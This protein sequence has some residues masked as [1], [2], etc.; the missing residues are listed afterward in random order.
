M[1]Q[2]LTLRFALPDELWC[3]VW[4]HLP[5]EARVA[6]SHVSRRWRAAALASSRLWSRIDFNTSL[7]DRRRCYCMSSPSDVVPGRFTDAVYA[8]LEARLAAGLRFISLALHRARPLPISFD[9]HV[10]CR[11]AN[12]A[13]ALL[14]LCA[15][16][17]PHAARL[18]SL[19][20]TSNEV[21]AFKAFAKAVFRSYPS[22][23]FP[24]LHH[25]KLSCIFDAER[26][27]VHK[28]VHI[29]YLPKMTPA[30]ES[31]DLFHDYTWWNCDRD[32]NPSLRVNAYPLPGTVLPALK[33]LRYTFR[34][35]R[36]C[37]TVLAPCPNLSIAHLSLYHPRYGRN[38][39]S[40]EIAE[41]DV[42]RVC[43]LAE[44]IARI[45]VYYIKD[46]AMAQHVRRMFARSDREELYIHQFGAA[47]LASLFAIFSDI[48]TYAQLRVEICAESGG[49]FAVQVQDPDGA[50]SRCV[51][52]A[53]YYM[54]P[55]GKGCSAPG[56]RDYTL[57]RLWSS[58]SPTLVRRLALPLHTWYAMTPFVPS[59]PVLECL[60]LGFASPQDLKIA[61]TEP[62]APLD[63]TVAIMTLPELR[64]VVLYAKRNQNV[65]LAI[66]VLD[67]IVSSFSCDVDTVRL[68]NI[69]LKV[70][71]DIDV[72]D[73]M[74]AGRV[75]RFWSVRELESYEMFL[76]GDEDVPA[77]LFKSTRM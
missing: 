65:R 26:P 39:I 71:C 53:P 67:N 72:S 74:P 56:A 57:P 33:E 27:W 18:R 30:L 70:P 23:A 6:V 75:E 9:V 42:A 22:P 43:T 11:T 8:S 32:G 38:S 17:R 46:D 31:L 12:N 54:L 36:D 16:I 13:P 4:E 50:R 19:S 28:R 25:L 40:T 69:D 5:L 1:S 7:H 21:D 51:S 34:D 60:M 41:E 20:F 29:P 14:Q 77:A 55:N 3:M 15:L 62:E 59:F 49:A 64:T 48:G 73:V 63:S 37:A 66:K 76:L 10:A 24:A 35:A 44:R 58:L 61:S 52:L 47:P 2:C 45:R 68:L